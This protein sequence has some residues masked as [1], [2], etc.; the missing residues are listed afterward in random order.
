MVY[1]HNGDNAIDMPMIQFENSNRC[2]YFFCVVVVVACL[3]FRINIRKTVRCCMHKVKM[4][5][6]KS[7]NM[8][9]FQR[10]PERD[11]KHTSTGMSIQSAFVMRFECV[12]CLFS[13]KIWSAHSISATFRFQVVGEFSADIHQKSKIKLFWVYYF[14]CSFQI[15]HFGFIT[16]RKLR[17]WKT[18]TPIFFIFRANVCESMSYNGEWTNTCNL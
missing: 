13:S 4:L 6:L 9:N 10:K 12:F 2:C 18:H 7:W 16:Y 17:E 3:Y 11:R 8:Y 5:F 15:D 14:I 1:R